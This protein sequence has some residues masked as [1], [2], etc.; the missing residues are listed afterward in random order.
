MSLVD[1]MLVVQ[2]KQDQPER[3]KLRMDQL[4]HKPVSQP[5]NN[6]TN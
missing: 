3:A 2:G 5:I 6:L 4:I 1:V